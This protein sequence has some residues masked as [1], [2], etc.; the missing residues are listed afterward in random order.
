MLGQILFA[1][2][3]FI[4]FIYILLLK[5]IKKND[6]TYLIMLCIQAIGIFLNLIKVYFDIFNR[7]RSNNYIISF[8]YNFTYNINYI[9]KMQYKCIRTF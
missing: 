4:L 5:L 6:T 1:I 8:M 9:G 7:N 2:I 3:A